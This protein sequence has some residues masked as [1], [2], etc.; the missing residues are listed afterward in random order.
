MLKIRCPFVAG[1]VFEHPEFRRPNR[2][3]K[4]NPIRCRIALGEVVCFAETFASKR[5]K[6]TIGYRTRTWVPFGETYSPCIR[7]GFGQR[8]D[9]PD[10]NT[11][12]GS[13]DGNRIVPPQEFRNRPTMHSG[14][15]PS[16]RIRASA[17]RKKRFSIPGRSTTRHSVDNRSGRRGYQK[18]P[19]TFNRRITVGSFAS[20][21]QRR[22]CRFL[23]DALGMGKPRPWFEIGKFVRQSQSD[24]P[25]GP[26]APSAVGPAST[27]STAVGI[28][29]WQAQ[30]P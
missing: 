18:K 10:A 9:F 16:I 17:C 12:P 8:R 22:K 29:A 25:T 5:A 14:R 24:R 30:L 11:S 3:R 28:P 7:I 26:E 1:S 2:H 23:I 15:S 21:S 19:G 13:G 6:A 4:L 27:A 20:L